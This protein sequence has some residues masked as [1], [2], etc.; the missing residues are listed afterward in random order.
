[1]EPKNT[2]GNTESTKSTHTPRAVTLS[3]RINTH[4]RTSPHKRTHFTHISPL[5][6]DKSSPQQQQP[7]HVSHHHTT[8]S[9]PLAAHRRTSPHKTISIHARDATA[10]TTA[11]HRRSNRRNNRV[12]RVSPSYSTIAAT[13]YIHQ[14]SAVDRR[15]SK[16]TQKTP[17]ATTRKV[18]FLNSSSV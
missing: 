11:A 18:H 15:P 10:H 14:G 4:R 9:P 6:T 12:N 13:R 16:V 8:L 1:M 17:A 2:K 3:P 7:Q 5:R